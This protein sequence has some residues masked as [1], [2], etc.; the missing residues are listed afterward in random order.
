MVSISM[1][2]GC[3]FRS[4]FIGRSPVPQRTGPPIE[5]DI[6]ETPDRRLFHY[7]KK[8]GRTMP[9]FITDGTRE[10]RSSARIPLPSDDQKPICT[11]PMHP[12]RGAETEIYATD[13]AFFYLDDKDGNRTTVRITGDPL[14]RIHH[15]LG[16]LFEGY[17]PLCKYPIPSA[18]GTEVERD[19]YALGDRLYYQIG[20]TTAVMITGDLSTEIRHELRV[21]IETD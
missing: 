18:D 19:V 15:K 10:I 13:G 11:Y 8:D 1:D 2:P 21:P 7:V 12:G 14:I 20:R 4:T 3:M 6:Y 17:R 9:V 16:M 5:M